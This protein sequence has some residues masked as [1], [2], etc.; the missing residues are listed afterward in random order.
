MNNMAEINRTIVALKEMCRKL[1]NRERIIEQA[2]M[3][4]YITWFE[5]QE[6]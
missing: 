3:Q 5:S 6:A 2:T 4:D 1:I